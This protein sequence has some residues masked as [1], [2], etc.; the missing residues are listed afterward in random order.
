M[1]DASSHGHYF[2]NFSTRWAKSLMMLMMIDA[3][4]EPKMHF[5]LIDC[6]CANEK[7]LFAVRN[8]PTKFGQFF[9]AVKVDSSFVVFVL[10]WHAEQI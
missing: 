3:L 8:L 7:C 10:V 2:N 6:S 5:K 9:L 4:N 1:K